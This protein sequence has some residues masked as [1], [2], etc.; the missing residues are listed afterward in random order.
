MD[1]QEIAKLRPLL[2]YARQA[3]EY[4][5]G[6]VHKEPLVELYDRVNPLKRLIDLAQEDAE[7]IDRAIALADDPRHWINFFRS[8]MY[9]TLERWK[10]RVSGMESEGARA[11]RR[12]GEEFPR[13]VDREFRES[14]GFYQNQNIYQG[15]ED[16]V[17]AAIVAAAQRRVKERHEDPRQRA[18]RAI[19]MREIMELE[20]LE[21]H[22][23][24]ISEGGGR[25]QHRQLPGIMETVGGGPSIAS[26]TA[27]PSNPSGRPPSRGPPP[28]RNGSKDKHSSPL[29]QEVTRR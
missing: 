19:A 22:P 13:R 4:V 25:G 11:R 14:L 23:S 9:G 10:P 27:G 17:P 18:R 8:D 7:G 3:Y 20:P 21:V 1:A 26:T 15:N 29:S 2:A 28:G 16:D 24:M 12:S 5:K 6:E